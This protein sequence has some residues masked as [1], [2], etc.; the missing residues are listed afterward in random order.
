VGLF[1]DNTPGEV[2]IT[3]AKEGSTIGGLMDTIGTLASLALQ[4]GVPV[5]AMVKKFAHQRFEPSGFTKNADIPNAKSVIDY[6]FR[7]M[8]FQFVSGYREANAPHRD[9]P[10]LPL[11]EIKDLDRKFLNK[12]V[13]DLPIDEDS[14]A[15]GKKSGNGHGG[16]APANL[17]ESVAHLMEDA[18]Q[19]PVCGHIAVRNGACYRCLNCGESLGCS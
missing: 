7:W 10:E 15:K 9:Q 19:C 8:A 4:Y 2:F 16:H 14:V 6:I 5:E 11:K 18:P 3:M 17:S 1:E 13:A 12:P